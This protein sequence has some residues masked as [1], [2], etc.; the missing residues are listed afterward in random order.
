MGSARSREVAAARG[1]QEGREGGDGG[2]G[3]G[4]AGGLASSAASEYM[5]AV[6]DLIACSQDKVRFV[7]ESEAVMNRFCRALL[8]IKRQGF[9]DERQI[10]ES[11]LEK[12]KVVHFLHDCVRNRFLVRHKV[13]EAKSLLIERSP[14]WSRCFERHVRDCPTCSTVDFTRSASAGVVVQG[15]E[16]QLRQKRPIP[17]CLELLALSGLVMPLFAVWQGNDCLRHWMLFGFGL[18]MVFPWA[19][20]QVLSFKKGRQWLLG[21]FLEGKY[22]FV[23]TQYQTLSWIWAPSRFQSL[24]NSEGQNTCS[25]FGWW[26]PVHRLEEGAAIRRVDSSSRFAIS[27]AALNWSDLEVCLQNDGTITDL[28][29][30]CCFDGSCI[31]LQRQQR[32]G[33]QEILVK[34]G[35]WRLDFVRKVLLALVALFV[36]AVLL[37]TCRQPGLSLSC[38]PSRLP[39]RAFFLLDASGS[40]TDEAWNAEKRG[41]VEIIESFESATASNTMTVG[42]AQFS[43]T[44][45]LEVSMTSDLVAA[46]NQI[47]EIEQHVGGTVFSNALRLCQQQLDQ[48]EKD[49]GTTFDICVLLTDGQTS[50]TRGSLVG[51]LKKTTALFGIFVGSS[52]TDAERLKELTGCG[53]ASA[54]PACHLFASARN[55][56]ELQTISRD[57]A[58]MVV[59]KVGEAKPPMPWRLFFSFLAA[60]PF[61]VW[62]VYLMIPKS[63]LGSLATSPAQQSHTA[64]QPLRLRTCGA[65]EGSRAP[66]NTA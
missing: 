49:P 31:R 23:G 63:S 56:Q 34:I 19:I 8:H 3:G 21:A 26:M 64:Q 45:S 22:A 58:D 1:E 4:G 54:D 24:S 37:A 51:L 47:Q 41:A 33:Q 50:D 27:C 46:K 44:A 2:G 35:C 52:K 12:E 53:A 40:V 13:G 10:L 14:E 38:G 55:F 11:S 5:A 48:N 57:V 30:N 7:N 6:E 59:S 25:S 9:S 66:G 61:V 62:W 18:S 60:L 42:A 28:P 43:D 15:A 16:T 36:I 20:L 39:L 17:F 29:P 65:N 32:E